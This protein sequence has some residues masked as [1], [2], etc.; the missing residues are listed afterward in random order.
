MHPLTLVLVPSLEILI[1]AVLASAGFMVVSIVELY[2]APVIWFVLL[3]DPAIVT[4]RGVCAIDAVVPR[5]LSGLI[6][7]RVTVQSNKKGASTDE[8]INYLYLFT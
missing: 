7:K 8:C 2:P 3:L 5:V 6:D 4:T 1:P